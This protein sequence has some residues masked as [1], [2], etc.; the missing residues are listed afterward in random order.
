MKTLLALFVLCVSLHAQ[1]VDTI[2]AG[3][4]WW[5]EYEHAEALPFKLFTVTGTNNATGQFVIT[6]ATQIKVASVSDLII[7]YTNGVTLLKGFRVNIETPMERGQY[8]IA[9]KV[10]DPALNI[11][12]DFS[13]VRE[14][15]AKP[16]A[17]I[18]TKASF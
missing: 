9:G 2:V 1:T 18:V 11:E 16:N 15:K 17:P 3:K 6:A 4:P 7:V 14:F 8:R 12:S 5:V 10:F 13:N